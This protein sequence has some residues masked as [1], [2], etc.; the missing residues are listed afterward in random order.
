M[1]SSYTP[2]FFCFAWLVEDS[3]ARFLKAERVSVNSYRSKC[4]DNHLSL[5]LAT[6][7]LAYRFS[8]LFFLQAIITEFDLSA[9]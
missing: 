2:E 7:L 3:T 8:L 9:I 1:H 5:V 6:P 4:T